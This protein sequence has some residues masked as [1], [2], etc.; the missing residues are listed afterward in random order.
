MNARL[1]VVPLA[2]VLALSTAAVAAPTKIAC[3]AIE[4][5]TG[6][7]FAVR[8]QDQQG[9]YGPQEDAFDIVTG[10]LASDGKTVTA[11]V[12][13]KKFSRTVASSPA[14]VVMGVD[15]LVGSGTD[16]V[17][18]KA[19]L[20]QGQPDRFEA[21]FKAGD[22]VANTPSTFVGTVTGVVDEAKNE[23]RIHAPVAMLSAFGA[24][25]KGTKLIPNANES[26]VVSRGVPPVTSSAGQPMTTRGPFADIAPGGKSVTVGAKTCVAVGK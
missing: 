3:N 19:V 22:A 13:V 18:L 14:G 26:A 6:D 25:K 7:T 2:A 21:S 16:I 4:D 5:A 15:F 10:D 20:I 11:V 24:I 8:S 9:V 12:R 23:V 1:A 17:S